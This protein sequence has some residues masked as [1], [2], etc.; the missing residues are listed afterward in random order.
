[1]TKPKLLVYDDRAWDFGTLARPRP[2]PA[3]LKSPAKLGNTRA[4][5]RQIF[6][7][8]DNR[9]I[10]DLL[11]SNQSL[12]DVFEFV[13]FFWPNHGVGV[14]TLLITTWDATDPPTAAR[15]RQFTYHRV[16]INHT[17]AAALPGETSRPPAACKVITIN[18][19]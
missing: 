17:G 14:Y 13:Y 4:S 6:R 9:P 5:I 7:S 8:G 19:S 16:T 12:G 3:R 11:M 1:V 10:L 2:L 18:V 15:P